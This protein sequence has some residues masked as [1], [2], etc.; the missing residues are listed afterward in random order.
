M[1]LSLGLRRR[2]DRGGDEL[3]RKPVESTARRESR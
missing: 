2:D 1:N 3:F